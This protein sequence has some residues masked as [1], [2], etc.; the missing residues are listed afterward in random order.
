[1]LPTGFSKV[2]HGA[3]QAN[4]SRGKQSFLSVF[5]IISLLRQTDS[6]W[7]T[8]KISNFLLHAITTITSLP[9]RPNE[10]SKY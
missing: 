3:V 2:E 4:I 8:K 9:S 5:Y 1:M 7:K 10:T 6:I